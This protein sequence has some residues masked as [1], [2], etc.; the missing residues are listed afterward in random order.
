MKKLLAVFVLLTL[1]LAANAVPAKPGL[2]SVIKLA[3]GTEVRAQL[4]GDEHMCWMR[5]ADGSCYVKRDGVYV[6]IDTQTL[7]TRRAQRAAAKRR[8]T[9][10]STDD[11]LGK[12]GVM[13]H[14]AVPSIGEY[15]IPVVMVQF[16]D[17]SFKST[18]TVEKMTR[19]YNEE[20]YADES[21][22]KG[23]VR[24]YFI[25]QS[26]GQFVPNFDVVGIVT[27]S[28]TSAYYGKDK[29]EDYLDENLDE[30]PGDVVA[31]AIDQLGTNFTKYIVKGAD[32]NHTTGVPLLCMLYAGKGQ[33]TDGDSDLIWPCEW[34]CNQDFS[35]VHFNSCFVG[36]ELLYSKLMGMAVFCHEFG[37]AL[38]LP[39][40]YVTDD[41]YS[42]DDSF[43]NWSIMD[44]GSYLDSECRAPI[45]YTAYEKSYMGWLDLKEIGDQNEVTLLSPL[46]LAEQ[47]AY[48][49]RN[50]Q[51]PTETFI[52]ENR[53]PGTWYPE[54]MSGGVMVS[55]IDY[56]Q[57]AWYMNTLN[58]TQ[59]KKRACILTA[60]GSKLDYSARKSNLYGIKK[61][62]IATLMTRGGTAMDIGISN[63]VMNSDGTA[64][65]TISDEPI[66]PDEPTDLF[67][68]SFDE[69]SG[70]GGNDGLWSG[71]IAFSQLYDD[72]F[73]VSGWSYNKGYVA[74]QCVRF[75]SSLEDGKVKTPYVTLDGEA[76]LTFRAGA[77][78]AEKNGTVLKATVSGGTISP[79]AFTLEKGAFKDYT[80][81]V[82][83]TSN[84]TITLTI[85]KGRFFLD[86]VKLKNSSTGIVELSTPASRAH[87]A[88]YYNLSGQRVMQPTRGLYI[89]NGK[90]VV[91]K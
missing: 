38:G 13:S 42:H 82:T 71:Q 86:E 17:K 37:H 22:C 41:S 27:L 45:G 85:D 84:I 15:T 44:T 63:I 21:G 30:L 24:D 62:V 34:D 39:D 72:C 54:N 51:N 59:K 58:N 5:T 65:L 11:G 29:S 53:Q 33:A 4:A 9:V 76:T 83:G 46:G 50:P 14:G 79:D 67:Y 20:G 6:P 10:S 64:V 35:G 2:W 28:N 32:E 23:S 61:T 18:T 47:S 66:T 7:R 87:D 78:D 8:I 75:G 89:I 68:E 73:D 60:D 31:A 88:T 1:T 80:A 91:V 40:F 56:N 81:T 12:Y 3:D 16:S 36:N 57:Y 69:C 48:I 25:A 74:N 26:G 43:G 77:W 70:T 19:F 90:K 49:I 55:R 52:F